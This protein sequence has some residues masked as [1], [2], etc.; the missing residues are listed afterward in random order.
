MKSRS[1]SFAEPKEAYDSHVFPGYRM[2]LFLSERI[3]ILLFF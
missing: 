2:L 1:K 3:E